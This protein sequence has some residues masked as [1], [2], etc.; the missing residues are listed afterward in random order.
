VLVIAVLI[1]ALVRHDWSKNA[2]DELNGE[3]M[4]DNLP[5]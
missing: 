4:D 5:E 1:F 3:R 2:D